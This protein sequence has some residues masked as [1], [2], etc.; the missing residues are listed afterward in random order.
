M[1]RNT[2]SIVLS[3]CHKVIIARQA[4]NLIAGPA[5]LYSLVCGTFSIVYWLSLIRKTFFFVDTFSFSSDR[6]LRSVGTHFLHRLCKFA[7]DT[8]K[9]EKEA[10][11]LPG[12]L[13]V[14]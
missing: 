1:K 9:A 12:L 14:S 6:R 11:N 7:H 5:G 2:Y 4:H 13:K 10:L 3:C 8:F